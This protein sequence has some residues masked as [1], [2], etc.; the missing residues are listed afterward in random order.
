MNFLQMPLHARTLVYMA[1]RA[2][3]VQEQEE[4]KPFFEEFVIQWTAHNKQLKASMDLLYDRFVVVM[5]DESFNGLSGCG[6]DKSV[7]F[8]KAIEGDFNVSFFN[9]LLVAYKK[10]DQVKTVNQHFI[11]GLIGS[12]DLNEDTMVFNNLVQTREQF[13]REWL[14]PLKNTWLAKYLKKVDA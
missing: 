11:S 13:D 8:L 4:L 1:D 9:R 14:A 6:I 7:N 5:V 2:F 3:N 12:G 10:E